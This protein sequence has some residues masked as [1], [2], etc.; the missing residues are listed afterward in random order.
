MSVPTAN[1]STFITI[2]SWLLIVGSS[3]NILTNGAQVIIGS[4]LEDTYPIMR[5]VFIVAGVGLSVNAGLLFAACA[6]LARKD[7]AR[8]IFAFNFGLGAVT[9]VIG[10]VGLFAFLLFSPQAESLPDSL[11]A[12]AAVPLAMA[13]LFAWLSRQLRS[14]AIRAEFA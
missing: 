14:E 3:F 12:A 8:K 11:F 13:A 6:L 7:W 2:L 1:R 9:S 5:L 10:G 4:M